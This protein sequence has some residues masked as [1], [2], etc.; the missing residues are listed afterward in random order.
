M[1]FRR[2]VLQPMCVFAERMQLRLNYFTVTGSGA[3]GRRRPSLPS[4]WL[5]PPLSVAA[6]VTSEDADC[7][8]SPDAE[9]KLQAPRELEEKDPTAA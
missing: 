3:P 2:L 8:F 6:A 7:R 9:G 1:W 5:P 4:F